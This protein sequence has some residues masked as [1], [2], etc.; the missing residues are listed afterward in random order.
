MGVVTPLL[1]T[2]GSLPPESPGFWLPFVSAQVVSHGVERLGRPR[3]AV[4][5][6]SKS[7]GLGCFE[8]SQKTLLNWGSYVNCVIVVISSCTS[9]QSVSTRRTSSIMRPSSSR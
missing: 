2:P 3:Y 8:S 9:I 5:C 4:C 1:G 6:C 7:K